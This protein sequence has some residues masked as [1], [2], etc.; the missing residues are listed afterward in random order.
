MNNK[1]NTTESSWLKQF[2]NENLW[3]ILLL[4]PLLVVAVFILQSVDLGHKK[5]SSHRGLAMVVGSV[6]VS[7]IELASIVAKP[8]SELL[9][10]D[11]YTKSNNRYKSGSLASLSNAKIDFR[12]EAYKRSY[13][14]QSVDYQSAKLISYEIVNGNQYKKR[15]NES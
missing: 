10:M 7:A 1:T 2:L 6:D 5:Q 8:F 14:K 11:V 3:F 15:A 9:A 12:H 13:D 4:M